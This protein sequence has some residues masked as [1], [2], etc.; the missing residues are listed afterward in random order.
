MMRLPLS[1]AA[2]CFC[3]STM[4]HF[5]LDEPKFLLIGEPGRKDENSDA[6][7]HL[8]FMKRRSFTPLHPMWD[9]WLWERGEGAGEIV[10][11]ESAG[12]PAW[13]CS[14]N[15]ERLRADISAEIASHNPELPT[16]DITE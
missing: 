4:A 12:I 7:M 3:Y 9:R 2:H 5:D 15:E 8:Q 11:M 14:P 6:R 10:R 1:R 16:I 13:F